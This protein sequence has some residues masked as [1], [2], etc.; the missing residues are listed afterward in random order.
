MLSQEI[1]GKERLI[2][3][4]SRTLTKAKKRYCVT[5]K[6]MLAV[7]HFIKHF[8][9]YLYGRQLIFSEQTRIPEMASQI[10]ESRSMAS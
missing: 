3:Y 9:H 6:E 5:R 10:Q 4:A 7:V 8:R 1:G 2:A